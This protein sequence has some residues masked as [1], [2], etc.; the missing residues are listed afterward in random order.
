MKAFLR[1]VLQL[2]DVTH[3]VTKQL[4]RP[5]VFEQALSILLSLILRR[6]GVFFRIG[7]INPQH[8]QSGMAFEQRIYI[9]CEFLVV[10]ITR[11]LIAVERS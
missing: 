5:R 11:P 2:P 10:F 4:V 7:K 6:L 1:P 9:F 8:Q 3:H